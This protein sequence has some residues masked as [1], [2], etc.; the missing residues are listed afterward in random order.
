[1][2]RVEAFLEV[3]NPSTP[4]PKGAR[5]AERVAGAIASAELLALA[6]KKKPVRTAVGVK[7]LV[8]ADGRVSGCSVTAPS[9]AK[10]VDD[11]VC[12]MVEERFQYRPARDAVGARIAASAEHSFTLEAK[13][14]K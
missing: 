12:A 1:M 7:F 5:A 13:A 10:P 11:N 14:A 8:E 6:G 9:G 3:H 4:P 2:K